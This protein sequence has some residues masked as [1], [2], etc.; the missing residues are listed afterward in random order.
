MSTEYT[1]LPLKDTLSKSVLMIASIFLFSIG[2][3]FSVVFFVPVP[4]SVVVSGHVTTERATR[5]VTH[6]RGG[7]IRHIKVFEGEF[8]EKGDVI[9]QFSDQILYSEREAVVTELIIFTAESESLKNTLNQDKAARFSPRIR[10][11]ADEYGLEEI[12]ML[13]VDRRMKQELT[14][15]NIS[16]GYKE[17]KKSLQRQLRNSQSQFKAK[18]EEMFLLSSLRKRK[19]HLMQEGIVAKSEVE[20]LEI[21]EAALRGDLKKIES[22]LATINGEI[23]Q[24]N[25]KSDRLPVENDFEGLS[26]LAELTRAIAENQ[27]RLVEIE[28]LIKAST[29]VAPISGQITNLSA[30]TIG[31]Y[32]TPAE[33]IANIV[34]IHEALII[35]ADFPPRD[36]HAISTG[37]SA[38]VVFS[39]LPQRNMPELTAYVESVSKDVSKDDRTGLEYYKARLRIPPNVKNANLF[40]E[41]QQLYA[42]LPVDVYVIVDRAPFINYIFKPLSRSFRKSF[43]A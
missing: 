36:S 24:I 3:V 32:V 25:L 14:A 2:V 34:P 41:E 28:K 40:H 9:L 37:M 31:S 18:Q 29:V 23:I 4:Q 10:R 38:K 6:D 11:L 7:V 26:R 22:E 16:E 12:L 19:Y 1:K 30:N 13:E 5:N 8:V 20:E 43:R 15:E 33:L 27:K 21:Q 39:S 17:S 42:G 35:E